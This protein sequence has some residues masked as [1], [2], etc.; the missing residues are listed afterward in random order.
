MQIPNGSFIK[1]EVAGDVYLNSSIILQDV[2]YLPEFAFNLVSIS[3][4][5]R[6]IRCGF[7][8]CGDECTIR[9]SYKKTTGLAKSLMGFI[10]WNSPSCLRSPATILHRF[11]VPLV[12]LVI[13]QF[14]LLILQFGILDWGMLPC[15]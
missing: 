8:F 14:Q 9:D 6:T 10:T 5:T 13:I 12:V 2:L 4:L 7:S 15:L 3:K 1:T 11:S